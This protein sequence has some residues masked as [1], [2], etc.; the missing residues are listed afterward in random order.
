MKHFLLIILLLS[1]LTT[2]IYL[3][4]KVIVVQLVI[5]SKLLPYYDWLVSFPGLQPL[6]EVPE[7]E[8]IPL[9]ETKEL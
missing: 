1:I 7:P 6:P 9:F 8:K 3:S 5:P 2:G 4:D